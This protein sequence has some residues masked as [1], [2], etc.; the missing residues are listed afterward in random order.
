MAR[1][2]LAENEGE[3]RMRTGAIP[4]REE[5]QAEALL[6]ELGERDSA[7]AGRIADTSA[8]PARRLVVERVRLVDRNARRI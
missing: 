2:V 6:N 7:L 1:Q 8:L 5:E 3:I 4:C